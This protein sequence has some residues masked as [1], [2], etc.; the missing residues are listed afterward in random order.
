MMARMLTLVRKEFVAL[1]R[2]RRARMI[3][4]M[5]PLLQLFVF[6]FAITLEVRNNSLTILNEDAGPHSQKCA[7]FLTGRP[8]RPIST[9]R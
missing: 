2:D 7:T 8:S 9:A 3:L 6:A 1:M 5:P 4:V